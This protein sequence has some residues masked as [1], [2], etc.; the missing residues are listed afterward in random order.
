MIVFIYKWLKNAV[1]RRSWRCSELTTSWVPK[2][3][4]LLCDAR[5][6]RLKTIILPRQAWD[7]HREGTQKEMR[8]PQAGRASS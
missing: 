1:F 7:K 3:R 5:H 4:C 2:K 8:F 6:F